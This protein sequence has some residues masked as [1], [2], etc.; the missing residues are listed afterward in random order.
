MVC[1]D[2]YVGIEGERSRKRAWWVRNDECCRRGVSSHV[3]NTINRTMEFN[4][5]R[6]RNCLAQLIGRVV[7][8]VAVFGIGQGKLRQKGPDNVEE[9]S[10][11]T[12]QETNVMG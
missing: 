8:K 4:R 9:F 7:I 6:R 1:I 5:C 12:R 11:G 3:N 10:I 2:R